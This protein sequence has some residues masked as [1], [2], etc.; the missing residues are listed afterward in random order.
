M[1]EPTP[2]PSAAAIADVLALWGVGGACLTPPLAALCPPGDTVVATART[3][4]ISVGDDG[5]GLSGIYDVL[6]QRLDGC[7]LVIA[8][9]ATL[10]GCMWGEVLTAAAAAMGAR[11][12]L[13]DGAVRDVAALAQFGVGVYG[14]SVGVAGPNGRAHLVGVDVPVSIGA[15]TIEPGSTIVADSGGCVRLPAALTE[16]AIAAAQRY[17]AGE[18]QV[19]HALANGARL[20]GVYQF[21]RDVVEQIRRQHPHTTA[22]QPAP[23][24]GG[25]S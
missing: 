20:S 21:K 17:E 2:V 15:V 7:A 16:A 1:S 25:I 12:V 23:T 6:S 5:P 11:A 13:I 10:G 18:A 4:Q 9:P 19:L 8:G 14:T 3:V 24:P 22:G